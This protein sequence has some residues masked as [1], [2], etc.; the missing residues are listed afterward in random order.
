MFI[1][2]IS[3]SMMFAIFFYIYSGCH[4]WLFITNRDEWVR[5]NKRE[6]KRSAKKREHREHREQVRH[7]AK[8][9]GNKRRHEEVMKD[10]DQAKR[11]L[12]NV[13]S[14]GEFYEI[15]YEEGFLLTE[16]ETQIMRAYQQHDDVE[17]SS[18]EIKQTF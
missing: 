18:K 3:M 1:V 14:R 15:L 2:I 16:I 6:E 5:L 17:E 7:L 11:D 10:Y 4:P 13:N 9:R 8:S 12:K